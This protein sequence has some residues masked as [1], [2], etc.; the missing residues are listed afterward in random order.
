MSDVTVVGAYLKLLIDGARKAGIFVDDL[1]AMP[2]IARAMEE[3][4]SRLHYQRARFLWE[5][6][7]KRSQNQYATDL[8]DKLNVNKGLSAHIR[9]KIIESIRNGQGGA[10]DVVAASANMTVR[11]L[12]RRLQEEQLSYRNLLDEVREGFAKRYL[13]E[14]SLSVTDIAFLLGFSEQSAFSRAFKRW[15]SLS[16]IE[17]RRKLDSMPS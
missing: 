2:D 8:I 12:Q 16:P 15:T 4:E 1:A 14:E 9:Q 17:F 11:T 7:P 5:E 6:I 3:P 13:G 10:L